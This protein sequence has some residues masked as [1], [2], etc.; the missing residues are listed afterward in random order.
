MDA[1]LWTETHAP[2]L[3]EL[4]QP[5]VRERLSRT[6]D[7]P[8][9]LV[10]RGPPG[11]GKTAAVRALAAEAHD[12]VDADLTE[13]NVADFF[14]RTKNGS[15]RIHAFRGSFR[16]RPRSRS[17]TAAARGGTSTNASGRSGT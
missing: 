16:V 3:S 17:S 1:P 14:D 7:E 6:V 10:I 11:A 13:I 4:P 8:M 9:N 12:D 15:G 2:S 5:E